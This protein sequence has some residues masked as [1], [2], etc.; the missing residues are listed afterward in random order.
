MSN[1]HFLP[2]ILFISME[3]NLDGKKIQT[4]YFSGGGGGSETDVLVICKG[5]NFEKDG[6]WH[7][8]NTLL[9]F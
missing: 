1:D 7:W 5:F 9:K 4:E 3:Y 8:T 2:S 6:D